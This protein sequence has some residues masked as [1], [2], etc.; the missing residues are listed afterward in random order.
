ML[1]Q[2]QWSCAD[3]VDADNYRKAC[4]YYAS[5]EVAFA[6]FRSNNSDYAVIL[7]GGAREIAL[8]AI[9]RFKKLGALDWLILNIDRLAL[10]DLYGSPRLYKFKQLRA[11]CSSSTLQYA[12]DTYNIGLL[13]I[14]Q[15]YPIDIVEVG[16]GFGGL[17]RQLCD[18]Y[19]V[20]SYTIIDLAE[21]LALARKYLEK[22]DLIPSFSFVDAANAS[23]YFASF[24]GA[25][26]FVASASLAELDLGLQDMYFEKIIQKCNS[27]Y[28]VYNTIHKTGHSDS[29]TK[30]LGL[31]EKSRKYIFTQNPWF[32]ILFIFISDSLPRIDSQGLKGVSGLELSLK[33]PIFLARRLFRALRYRLLG[34][35]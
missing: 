14:C 30:N 33:S 26:L 25:H 9:R 2:N 24:K 28:L 6:E 27:A 23:E 7:E 12:L 15:T 16:G 5:S 21:P 4:A 18:I 31:L 34:I 32:R 35:Y 29:L 10:N 20:R 3:R 22:Y 19:N 8:A 1:V 11:E 17:A 13:G